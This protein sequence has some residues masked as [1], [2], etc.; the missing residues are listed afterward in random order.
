MTDSGTNVK[1]LPAA[2]DF[3]YRSAFPALSQEINGH[4][5]IYLD[6]AA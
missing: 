6:S 4:P 2:G 3:D 5:L 1:S